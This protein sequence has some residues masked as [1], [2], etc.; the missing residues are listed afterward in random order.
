MDLHH[1]N[2]NRRPRSFVPRCEALEHRC[3]PS[4]NIVTLG[5]TMFV[6]GDAAANTV[7][8]QDDGHGNV[9]ASITSPT[10]TASATK[11][12]INAIL[13]DT[14]G[15]DD[16]INYALTGDVVQRMALAIYAGTGND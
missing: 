6:I 7:T 16:V 4:A 1:V 5:H 14:R 8:I 12:G 10:G 3:C 15:G 13:V 2:G 9:T 11:S